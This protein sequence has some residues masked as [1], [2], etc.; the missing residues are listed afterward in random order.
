MVDAMS[1]YKIC[2]VTENISKLRSLEQRGLVTYDDG[3]RGNNKFMAGSFLW[4][5]NT[6]RNFRNCIYL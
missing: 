1:L 6:I 2:Y 5:M 4:Q 3:N